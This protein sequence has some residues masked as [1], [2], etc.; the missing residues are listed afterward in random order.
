MFASPDDQVSVPDLAGMT[1]QKAR[2]ALGDAGL[3]VGTVDRAFDNNVKANRV[4]SQ[5]PG[6][7]ESVDRGHHG[8]LH[9]LAR[10]PPD[11]G[12]LR[13]R[14]DP[15]SRRPAALED[16]HLDAVFKPVDSDQPKGTV[17][18]T[19]PAGEHAGAAGLR[20]SP[21]RCRKGPQKVPDVVGLQQNEAEKSCGTPASC[22]SRC[23]STLRRAEGRGHPADPAAPGQP[24][25]RRAPRSTIVVS[26]GPSSPPTSPT[27]P[28]TAPTLHRPAVTADLGRPD[29]ATGRRAG[30]RPAVSS[31]LGCSAARGQDPGV[32]HADQPVVRRCGDP[33]LDLLVP[34]DARCR[35]RRRPPG[36]PAGRGRS[37]ISAAERGGVAD[38]GDARRA[39]CRARPAAARSCRCSGCRWC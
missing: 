24:A 4:I 23:A 21:S 30:L 33:V 9:A 14:P 3:E 26:S 38:R 27:S 6:A 2:A 35:G 25:A 29:R 34:A 32:R 20:R 12:A 31:T 8:R 7:D 39:G 19:D 28:T 1:E 16:A 15:S 10:H 13:D 36:R 11:P 37:A 18:S 5:D 22:R 17:V